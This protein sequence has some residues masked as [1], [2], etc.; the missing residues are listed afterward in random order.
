MIK[1]EEQLTEY[2]RTDHRFAILRDYRLDEDILK[3]GTTS[4]VSQYIFRCYVEIV[5]PISN[6]IKELMI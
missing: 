4:F 3:L 1:V 5:L 2:F 6:Q